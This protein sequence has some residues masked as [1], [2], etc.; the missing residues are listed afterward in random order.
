MGRRINASGTLTCDDL[1]VSFLDASG[2]RFRA[3]DIPG[4]TVEPGSFHVVTGPSGSGKSTLLYAIA[5]LGEVESGRISFGEVV[6]TDLSEAGRDA[7]RRQ[8]V[9]MVFQTFHLISELNAEDNVLLPAWFGSFRA[10]EA[11]KARAKNLL[12]GLGVPAGRGVVSRLSRGE[13]QRVALARAL[14]FDPPI[15]LA[16]EPTASLDAEAG[17]MVIAML[18]RLA[19]EEGRTVL[20]VSHDPAMIDEADRTIRLERGRLAGDRAA[21]AAA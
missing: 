13:Q 1:V 7:W 20:A 14:L 5:G 12:D 19:R 2:S 15:I 10:D 21:D 6:I 11:L 17:E 8:H 9:G 16:D 18:A 4:V 3:L